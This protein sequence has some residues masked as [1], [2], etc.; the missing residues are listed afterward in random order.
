MNV[1]KTQRKF[2]ENYINERK[3]F[4]DGKE[5]FQT[6]HSIYNEN[7]KETFKEVTNFFKISNSED[8]SVKIQ[9]RLF[10]YYL[11]RNDINRLKMDFINFQMK[12]ILDRISIGYYFPFF[13]MEKEIVDPADVTKLIN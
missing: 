3:I 5:V 8:L 2:K 13:K 7:L 10:Y 12:Y 6:L 11:P 9:L 1:S 4:Q